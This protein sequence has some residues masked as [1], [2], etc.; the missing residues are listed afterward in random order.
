[1]QL[2]DDL[3][4]YVSVCQSHP[5]ACAFSLFEICISGQAVYPIDNPQRLK[6]FFSAGLKQFGYN[7][8]FQIADVDDLQYNGVLRHYPRQLRYDR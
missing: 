8:E 7:R 4:T 1:M 6:S 3:H 5:T 2:L